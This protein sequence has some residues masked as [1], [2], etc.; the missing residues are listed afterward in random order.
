MKWTE[1]YGGKAWANIAHLAKEMWLQKEYTIAEMTML[2][3][4]VFQTE[5]NTGMVFDKDEQ[6]VHHSIID[7]KK[8]LDAKF[9]AKTLKELYTQVKDKIYD[10][11]A[12][13]RITNIVKTWK[14]IM[15][16]PLRGLGD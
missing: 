4:R 2:L 15:Q 16:I 11:K 1:R 6:H 9:R 13:K 3:D 14:H 5:H 10:E 8:I 7:S 12:Q